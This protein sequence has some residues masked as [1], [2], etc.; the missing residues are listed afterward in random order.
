[1]PVRRSI[2]CVLLDPPLGRFLCFLT[3]RRNSLEYLLHA[4]GSSVEEWLDLLLDRVLNFG[5]LLVK[6]SVGGKDAAEFVDRSSQAVGNVLEVALNLRR[7][8]IGTGLN[9]LEFGKHGV[10]E[11]VDLRLSDYIGGGSGFDDLVGGG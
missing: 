11:F 7:E 8:L 10:T 1:M 6:G 5:C 4:G 2:L 9:L 3:T